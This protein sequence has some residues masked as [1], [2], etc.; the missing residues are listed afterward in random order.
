MPVKKRYVMDQWYE[1]APVTFAILL[2]L[3]LFGACPLGV[4]I[5]RFARN[6]SDS[7]HSEIV[8]YT[9]TLLCW[10]SFMLGTRYR[11]GRNNKAV[12][13]SV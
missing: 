6:P 3:A 8:G 1:M 4:H 9:M 7:V 10:M 13:G 2:F 5:N 12:E 11:V